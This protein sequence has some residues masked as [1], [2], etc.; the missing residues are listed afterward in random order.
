MGRKRRLVAASPLARVRLPSTLR[1]STALGYMNL[2][3]G[4]EPVAVDVLAE[5]LRG[6]LA[7]GVIGT[8][9][10]WKREAT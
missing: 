8:I 5:T 3:K 6:A 4:F 9:L 2:F 10:G 1:P 7:G